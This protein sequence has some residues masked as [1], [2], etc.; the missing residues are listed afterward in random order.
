M[1]TVAIGIGIR[2][3]IGTRVGSVETLLHITIKVIFIGVGLRVGL[4]IGV[5]QWKHTIMQERE[6]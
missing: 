3:C 6:N 4:G 5:G 1:G 2:T